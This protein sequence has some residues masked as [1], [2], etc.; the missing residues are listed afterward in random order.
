MSNVNVTITRYNPA[1]DD[2][3]RHSTYEV[4]WR[5]YMTVLQ[6]LHHINEY[7]EPLNFDFSCRGGLCGRCGATVNGKAE[8]SCFRVINEGEDV[9]VEPLV[10]FPVIRDLVVDKRELEDQLAKSNAELVVD[11]PIDID[12]MP[13]LDYDYWWQDLHRKNMCR[14]CGLCFSTCP[15]YQ[16][17]KTAY[18]GPA[19]LSQ[20]YLRANDGMD[21][22]DRI[23]QAVD[24]GVMNC[25]LCGECNKVCPSYID[26]VDCNRFFQE[27]AKARG[28]AQ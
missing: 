13:E 24:L 14:E 4:P 7:Y 20:V 17:D 18:A 11:D 27:A 6:A 12:A 1:E 15:V 2:A 5:E 23:A 19:T 8:L 28:L 10:G 16:S 21:K 25:T 26:H 22:A 9:T 3:P